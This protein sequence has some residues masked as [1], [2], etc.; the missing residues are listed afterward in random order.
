MKPLYTPEEFEAARGSDL[1]PCE[2]EMCGQTF[3]Q[4]KKWIKYALRTRPDPIR[5]CGQDCSKAYSKTY[6]SNTHHLVCGYCGKPI[7]KCNKDY[8]M[9]K[10]GLCFCSHSCAA[11]YNN[12]HKK[13]GYRRSKLEAY[14][15]EKLT[16]SYPDLEIVY[17][18]KSAIYSELDI[19]IPSLKLAFELNGIVHYEP[20]FGEDKF[21]M[22]QKNDQNKFYE[23]QKHN[24]SLCTID[25]SG[26]KYFKELNA[27]KYLD[28]IIDIINQ[29]RLLL[30]SKNL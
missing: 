29:H 15:E 28:L 1:M 11:S 14:V 25:T 26:L 6:L 16:E 9:S 18:D 20:I 7:E 4:P 5:F 3:Y 8:Q 23:C 10:S 22:I 27:K 24:I 19:Y 2:C 17:N 21:A 12:K 13:T 30:D